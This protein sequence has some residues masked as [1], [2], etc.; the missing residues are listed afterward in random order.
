METSRKKW[1]GKED[2]DIKRKA[3]GS[4]TLSLPPDLEDYKTRSARM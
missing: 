3:V 2:K 4:S 1:G